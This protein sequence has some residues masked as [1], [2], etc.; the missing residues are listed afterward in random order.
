MPA[1]QESVLYCLNLGE[2]G[3]KIVVAYTSRV[4]SI[5]ERNYCVT[6]KEL[7][8]V[9]TFLQHFKQYLIGSPFTIRKDNSALTWLQ[10]FKQP[11]GQLARWL[12]KLQEFQFTIIHHPGKAH[13]NADALFRRHCG[14]ECPDAHGNTKIVATITL[15]G[16]STAELRQAQLEDPNRPVTRLF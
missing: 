5:Q 8:A 13:S 3:S 11:E 15:T 16:Y 7:L 12:E 10:N 9:V 1:R 14:K 6:Q 4:L 2:D